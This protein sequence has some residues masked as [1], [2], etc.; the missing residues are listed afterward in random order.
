MIF[1]TKKWRIVCYLP[2]NLV[3]LKNNLYPCIVLRSQDASV[4]ANFGHKKFKYLS[5]FH[6]TLN[7]DAYLNFL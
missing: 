1:Y 4:K 5:K 3:Y 6:L 2:D 7:F